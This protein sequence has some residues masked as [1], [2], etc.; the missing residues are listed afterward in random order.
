[1]KITKAL[2]IFMLV[3][4]MCMTSIPTFANEAQHN[5]S[6]NVMPLSSHTDNATFTFS[7]TSNGGY[8]AVTY[9]GYESFVRAELTVKVQK[10]FLWAFWSDVDEWSTSSTAINPILEHVFTLKGAGTYKA[11]FT[12]VVTGSDG[13]VDTIT[14][15]IESKY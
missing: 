3:L 15:T 14:D 2:I 13:T 12:L 4:V 9:R 8:T 11:T 5:E 7:A 1:M 10:R 6:S